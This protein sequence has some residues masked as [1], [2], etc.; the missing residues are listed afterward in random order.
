MTDDICSTCPHW[1]P[2]SEHAATISFGAVFECFVSVQVVSVSVQAALAAD[3]GVKRVIWF[4]DVLY[5]W[6][7]LGGLVGGQPRCLRLPSHKSTIRRLEC[8]MVCSIVR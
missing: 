4:A 5:Y 3:D 2:V 8:G 6:G 7:W 1:S